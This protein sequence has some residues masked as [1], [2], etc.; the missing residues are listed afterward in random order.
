MK[1]QG[2]A[3]QISRLESREGNH[4]VAPS[5]L[6][7]NIETYG[8]PGFMLYFIL[9]WWP[10]FNFLFLFFMISFYYY[11]WKIGWLILYLSLYRFNFVISINSIHFYFLYFLVHWVFFSTLGVLRIFLWYNELETPYIL[12]NIYFQR[13][14]SWAV[15]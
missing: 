14:L 1:L 10:L 8:T 11:H 12:Q 3:K 7:L 13:E 4:R 2:N 9:P 15:L 5:P 6:K